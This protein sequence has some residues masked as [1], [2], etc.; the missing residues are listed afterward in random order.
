[1]KPKEIS[2]FIFIGIILFISACSSPLSSAINDPAVATTENIEVPAAVVE[3]EE[4]VIPITG[5][6]EETPAEEPG[7]P[8]ITHVDVPGGL[9]EERITST[10]DQDSS[11]SADQRRS[12]GGDRFT[13]NE[14]ERPFNANTMDIYF[15]DLDIIEAQVFN[16]SPWMF[17]TITLKGQNHEGMTGGRYALEIDLDVDARGDWMIFVISP[18]GTAWTTERVQVW[19]DMNKD[20]GG[21]KAGYADE[22]PGSRDGFETIVFDNGLGDDPD[23]AWVRVDPQDAN[24]VQIAFKESLI[25]G[26]PHYTIGAWA[27]NGFEPPMFDL[28][29]FYTKEQAGSPLIEYEYFYPIKELSGLDNTCRMPVGFA[30]TGAEFGVCA[31]LVKSNGDTCAG[32]PANGC[33]RGYVWNNE[34]CSCVRR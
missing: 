12:P 15:P 4:A 30:S 18:S 22:A 7:V 33:P 34:S 28:N 6:T 16:A 14:F 32:P 20:V 9:P 29:D 31:G 26:D 1:M 25:G 23:M 10:G 11:I 5:A 17:V 24:T 19:R 2:V 8:V 21:Q 3:A 13:F 27:G